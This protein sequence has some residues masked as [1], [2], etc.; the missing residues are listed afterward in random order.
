MHAPSFF[1]WMHRYVRSSQETVAVLG[2]DQPHSHP[3]MPAAVNLRKNKKRRKK[4]KQKKKV[5]APASSSPRKWTLLTLP[6]KQCE[7]PNCKLV[8]RFDRKRSP[9]WWCTS[10]FLYSLN[11]GFHSVRR[12]KLIEISRNSRKKEDFVIQSVLLSFCNTICFWK[13]TAQAWAKHNGNFSRD[14]LILI[15]KFLG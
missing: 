7:S 4:Q 6:I 10:S 11:T 3:E 14:L 12:R 15:N 9:W 2:L 13:A 5:T 8:W 1:F